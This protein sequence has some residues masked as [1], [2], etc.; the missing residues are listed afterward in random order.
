MKKK[1]SALQT[2]ALLVLVSITAFLGLSLPIVALVY[3]IILTFI[4]LRQGVSK[5]IIAF[6]T[7]I[8]VLGLI[9]RQVDSL[10]IPLQYGI[11][12]LVTA[13]LINKKYPVNKIIFFTSSLVFAMVLVHMGLRWYFTDINTF[14]ELENSLIDIANQQIAVI[15]EGDMGESEISQLS[16]LLRSVSTYISSIVPALLLISSTA[17]AYINYYVSVRLA[18]RSGS[19]IKN[20]PKFSKIIFPKSVITGFATL[21][22]LS[23]ALKYVNGFNYIQLLDNIFVIMFSV[24][25]I[26]GVSLALYVIEKMKIGRVFK[27]IFIIALLLSSFLNIVLFSLGVVDII[28]DFRKLRKTNNV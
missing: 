17:I 5:S 12:S 19:E 1:E 24:F 15:K 14:V 9:T 18:R 3:P 11:L 4:G 10:V 20:F 27:T 7:S 22:I 6:V 8:V 26:Q 16:N 28:I 23:Y 13:I 25:L 21:L 2:I